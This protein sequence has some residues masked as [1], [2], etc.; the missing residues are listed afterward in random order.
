[1]RSERHSW[2]VFLSY[3]DLGVRHDRCDGNLLEDCGNAR[4]NRNDGFFEGFATEIGV[5]P[6][7]EIGLSR[8]GKMVRNFKGADRVAQKN[9][10]LTRLSFE[11]LVDAP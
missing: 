11:H 1:M 10:N 2:E 3:D 6:V 5:L 8:K 4:G 9:T 7:I